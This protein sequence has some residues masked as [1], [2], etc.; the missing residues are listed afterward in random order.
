MRIF[1]QHASAEFNAKLDAQLTVL[2]RDVSE[3]LKENLVVLVLGGGYG[4]SEGGVFVD[5]GVE[6]PYNDLDLTLVVRNAHTIDR[7]TLTHIQRKH[8][9]ILGI[10]V[11][12]SR[13]LT[14]EMVSR[15]PHTLMWQD[16]MGGHIV[17]AGDRSVL[18]SNAPASL[19]QTLPRIEATRLLLNRGAGL[20]LALLVQ[21]GMEAAPD[22]DFVRR[23]AFKCRLAL[24]DSLLI[25]H[26]SY[27][28]AYTGRDRKLAELEAR[29]SIVA[30][31]GLLPNY[32]EAL[33]FKFLPNSVASF[34]PSASELFEI[35]KQWGMVLLYCESLRTGRSWNN[36]K[37]Y[38]EWN[39]VRE[40]EQNTPKQLF[41]NLVRNLQNGVFS[42][43]YPREALYRQ[44]PMLLGLT[45]EP[46]SHTKAQ[47]FLELWRK[48][49]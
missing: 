32:M 39:G 28:V 26:D 25:A 4:R 12:F 40:P 19:S 38:V 24:G 43:L 21:S 10:H 46:L 16:L 2:A 23:N 37:E 3:M 31:F 42:V 7:D 41:R 15:L 5:N 44:L 6:L 29:D 9:A 18:P 48:F 47:A 27:Q 45:G 33:K 20:L 17:L 1:A 22:A 49:N 8:E 34:Q 35:A 11:D 13:P 36:L 30:G 14:V